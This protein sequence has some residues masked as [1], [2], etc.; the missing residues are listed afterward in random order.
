MPSIP[1]FRQCP[2]DEPGAS[3][4]NDWIYAAAC[5]LKRSK[6]EHSRAVDMLRAAMTRKEKFPR[7]I[8]RQVERAYGVAF[9]ASSTAT[10][11]SDVEQFNPDL[12]VERASQI[13]FAV[14]PDWLRARSPHAVSVTPTQFLDA[15]FKP[16]ERVM[17]MR[18]YSD[19]G[20]PYQPRNADHAERLERVLKHNE[21][22]AWFICNP[23]DGK[24]KKGENVIDWRFCLLESDEEDY[25]QCWLRMLVQEPLRIVALTESGNTSVHALLKIDATCRTEFDSVTKGLAATYGP[26]GACVKSLTT[27]ERLTRL[28][29]VTRGD[30][31]RSQHLLYLNPSADSTPILHREPFEP[32]F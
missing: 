26:L 28:A 9:T 20:F 3:C 21:K 24:G 17:V 32:L 15:L 14:M 10:R 22:G 6:V 27:D 19:A 13:D 2:P 11:K 8:E 29:N 31:Q 16:S 25:G 18:S 1:L 12:L 23:T 5:T 7:E 4:I 30:N